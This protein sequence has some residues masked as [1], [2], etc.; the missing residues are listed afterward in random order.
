MLTMADLDGFARDYYLAPA[1]PDHH[2]ENQMQRDSTPRILAYIPE[3]ASVLELGTGDGLLTAAL[4][5]AGIEAE[6]LEGSPIL[7]RRARER[8]GPALSVHH[9]LFETFTPAR[10]YDA[11]LA[12]HVLEHLDDPIAILRRIAAWLKPGGTLIIVVPNRASIHRRVALRMG[13]IPEL[14]DLSAR[15]HLVGHQRVYDLATLEQH[16]AAAG[17]AVEARFGSFLKTLPNSMMLG[18]PGPLLSALDAIS[19]ELPPD[20]LA[21]IGIMARRP[22]LNDKPPQAG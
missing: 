2:I 7:C 5:Q 17:L 14:D 20:L 9:A 15:D 18:F 21:N 16:V 19:D 13:L 8:H 22:A 12:L 10:A 4:Q 6:L 11:V 1:I 3:G